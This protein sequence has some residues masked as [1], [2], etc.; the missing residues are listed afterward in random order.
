MS[1]SIRRRE[2]HDGINIKNNKVESKN[3]AV[4]ATS[5]TRGNAL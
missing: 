1:R 4:K 2:C 3:K 5:Y